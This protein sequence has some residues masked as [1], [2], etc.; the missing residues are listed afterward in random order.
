MNTASGSNRS[1]A[2][3]GRARG[4]A[5][6]PWSDRAIN[7]CISMGLSSPRAERPVGCSCQPSI[8]PPF[9]SRSLLS[10]KNKAWGQR[11]TCSWSSIKLAGTRVPISSF[12]KG[13]TYCSCPLIR[14]SCNQQNACGPS[15]T[16]RSPIGSGLRWT[17]WNRFR[18]SA[19]AGYKLIL[20]VFGAEPPSIGG[21]L[22]TLPKRI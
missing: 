9:P 11:N 3:S 14:Q 4:P 5:C 6:G 17:S 18:P 20:K 7:G 22:W 12:L 10:P 1:C 19:V 8:P 16:N 13:C 2:A 15:P 21:L